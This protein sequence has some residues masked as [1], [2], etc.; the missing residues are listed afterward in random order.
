[1]NLGLRFLLEMIALVSLGCWGFKVNEALILKVCLGIGL[2]VTIAIIWGLFGSAKAIWPFANP[3]QWILLFMI[4]ISSALALCRLGE[5]YLG[6]IYLV[7]AVIN[8]LFMYIWK[9]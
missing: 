3:F 4:Y 6:I 9:Q 5:K 1:M 2:P 8:S 7:T